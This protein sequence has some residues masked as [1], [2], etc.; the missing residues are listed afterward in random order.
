M[1]HENLSHRVWNEDFCIDTALRA[2]KPTLETLS[3]RL[4]W[5]RS[6][7]GLRKSLSRLEW[8]ATQVTLDDILR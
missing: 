5:T 2:N 4:V 8:R 3:A 7:K 6:D 1:F